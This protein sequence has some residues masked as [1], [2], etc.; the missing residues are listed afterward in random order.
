MVLASWRGGRAGGLGKEPSTT[1][2]GRTAAAATPSGQVDWPKIKIAGDF[3][4]PDGVTNAADGSGRLF[5]SAQAGGVPVVQ[6]GKLRSAPFLDTPDRVKCCA[7]EQG[8]FDVAYPPGFATKKHFYVTYPSK[9][10]GA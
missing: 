3:D 2:I 9:S 5:V 10:H 6:A 7:G 8:F 4:K 1:A